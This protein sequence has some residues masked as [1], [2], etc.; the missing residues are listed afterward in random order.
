MWSPPLPAPP[1]LGP[2]ALPEAGRKRGRWIVVASIAAVLVIG[3]AIAFV[4]TRGEDGGLPESVLGIPRLHGPEADEFDR[5]LRSPT[6][7]GAQ[8]RGAIYGTSAEPLLIVFVVEEDELPSLSLEATFRAAVIGFE[9]SAGGTTVVD[10]DALVQET[11]GSTDLMCA[12]MQ[13]STPVAPPGGAFCMWE[14]ETTGMVISLRSSD[15]SAALNDT[16]AVAEA[17]DG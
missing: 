2:P 13:W 11:A 5:V 15:P 7:A 12:P 1:A 3:V 8:L 17:I 4:L 9:D 10:E 14:G 16:Q 6:M